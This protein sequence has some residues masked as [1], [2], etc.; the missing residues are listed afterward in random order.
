MKTAGLF[1]IVSLLAACA[2]VQNEQ[3]A[4]SPSA[5]TRC[6]EFAKIAND[7]STTAYRRATAVEQLRAQRC[8][9][10]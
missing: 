10:Y 5:D 4:L 1:L 7:M 6:M 9:G 2:Q 3:P 8:P